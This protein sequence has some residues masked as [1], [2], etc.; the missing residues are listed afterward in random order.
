M[1]EEGWMMNESRFSN[2]MLRLDAFKPYFIA[3]NKRLWVRV[4]DPGGDIINGYEPKED[5][6]QW[7]QTKAAR[8]AISKKSGVDVEGYRDYRGREVIGAWHWDERLNAA[9]IVEQDASEAYAALRWVD[10]AGR[11][12]WGI[13]F[14]CAVGIFGR[15][16]WRHWQRRG[17]P[18]EKLGPYKIVGKIG[19]G[20]LGVVYRAEHQLLGRPAAI[21]L[22]KQTSV[23]RHALVRFE[24]EVRLAARLV[25]PNAVNIYDFGTT[26]WGE[27]YYAMEYIPGVNL[28]DFTAYA[29]TIP[30][31]RCL[32]L[33]I[34]VCGA[35]RE[36]H[37]EGL[38]H[39]DIKP[40]NIMV[41]LRGG[42]PDVVKVLDYGLVKSF[43]HSR[44]KM[45][46]ETRVVMGTPKFMAPERLDT[47]WLA[48]PRIDI[49]SIGPFSIT[50]C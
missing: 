2:E 18:P 33:M 9:L 35:I 47:P 42:I 22:L 30:L 1:D 11:I 19:E 5:A 16:A 36:A 13:P 26:E 8:G 32:H 29:N 39:R 50:S 25:H 41:C 3:D 20:G 21:K 28:A 6:T 14:L 38:V 46:T 7:A 17:L 27:F 24:R 10:T 34:Q 48:D 31:D 37:L 12:A 23:D 45:A 15:S 4:A 44:D 40:Q 49:F 43:R